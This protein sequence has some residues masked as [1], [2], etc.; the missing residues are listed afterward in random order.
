MH[1]WRIQV[2][3]ESTLV[4]KGFGENRQK[5][6]E[7]SKVSSHDRGLDHLLDAMVTRD[8]GRIDRTHFGAATFR[9][10]WLSRQTLAPSCGPCFKD[11]LI[12]KKASQWVLRSPLTRG[13]TQAAKGQR[14]VCPIGREQAQEFVDKFQVVISNSGKPELLPHAGE[15]GD[16]EPGRKAFEHVL[17]TLHCLLLISIDERQQRL[18]KARFQVA[19]WG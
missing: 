8:E 18:R 14:E 5:L 10:F 12:M 3:R 9:A 15:I 17:G 6:L 2:A 4:F 7:R 13:I 1:L 11:P 16:V 19:I